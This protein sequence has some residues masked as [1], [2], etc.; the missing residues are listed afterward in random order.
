MALSPGRVS[1]QT[2][3]KTLRGISKTG[4][5]AGVE[6]ALSE[7]GLKRLMAKPSVSRQEMR[8]ALNTLK[9]TDGVAKRTGWQ[10]SQVINRAL[11]DEASANQSPQ[12]AQQKLKEIKDRN[13]KQRRGN[14]LAE[15]LFKRQGLSLEELRASAQR[16]HQRQVT[17][18]ETGIKAVSKKYEKSE[19]KS[20][21]RSYVPVTGQGN[22]ISNIRRARPN[23]E[24]F[25]SRGAPKYTTDSRSQPDNDDEPD[26]NE[27]VISKNTK[28]GSDKNQPKQEPNLP[29]NP[30]DDMA[31]D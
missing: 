28:N 27:N 13:I 29:E 8:K 7:Q 16:A 1:Q 17:D 24:S 9:G 10:T 23:I 2:F 20:S 6:K 4:R 18:A 3:I 5:I 19:A 25:E 15:G 14:E 22:S 31:I 11:K 12:S 21:N 30:P 26:R